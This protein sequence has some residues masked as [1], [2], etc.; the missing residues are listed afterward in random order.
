ML[1][2]PCSAAVSAFDQV[3]SDQKLILL[4]ILDDKRIAW[5]NFDDGVF[6]AADSDSVSNLHAA[7]SARS[8]S[9]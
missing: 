8:L 6:A 3:V 5:A 2:P 4:L 1:P 7:A 9:D